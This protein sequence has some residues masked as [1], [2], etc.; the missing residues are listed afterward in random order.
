MS[1]TDSVKLGRRTKRVD[2]RTISWEALSPGPW[3]PPAS[4]NFDAEHHDAIP[5]PMLGND[6]YGDCVKAEQAHHQMRFEYDEQGAVIPVTTAEVVAQY[7]IETGGADNG[8]VILDSLK[9]WRRGWAMGGRVY[10]IHSFARVLAQNHAQFKEAL[11]AGSGLVLGLALPRSINADMQAG[12]PW[13][14]HAG[15]DGEPNSLGGHCV[16]AFGYDAD[17]V[18]IVSWGAKYRLT[19]AFVD[20]YCDECFVVIDNPDTLPTLTRGAL[21]GA[22]AG[23]KS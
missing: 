10:S 22:L 4:Y 20:E 15:P 23:I 21:F 11:V 2:P 13:G 8:L 9:V 19:W 5:T 3:T 17:G 7:L 1:I 6:R 18:D 12:R 16:L 14:V